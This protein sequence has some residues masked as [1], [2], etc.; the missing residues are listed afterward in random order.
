MSRD[1]SV[2][3]A[4]CS[5]SHHFPKPSAVKQDARSSTAKDPMNRGG[6]AMLLLLTKAA[7]F[8][9]NP[10]AASRTTLS[11]S[12]RLAPEARS[13]VLQPDS[14]FKRDASSARERLTGHGQ[15]Y[16]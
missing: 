13:F 5:P 9:T 8:S 14:G 10:L 4:L 16:V 15:G 6:A 7:I 12:R 1:Y 2:R 11:F 3:H